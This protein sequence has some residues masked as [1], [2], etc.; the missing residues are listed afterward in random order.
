MILWKQRFYVAYDSVA[1][2]VVK[3]GSRSRKEKQKN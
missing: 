3:L 2:A 1:Y